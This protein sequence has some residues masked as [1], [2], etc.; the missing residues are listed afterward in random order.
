MSRRTAQRLVMT[1]T[2]ELHQAEVVAQNW[3]HSFLNLADDEK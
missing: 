2:L 1:F 3:R